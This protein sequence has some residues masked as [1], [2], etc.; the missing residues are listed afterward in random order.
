MSLKLLKYWFERV[1]ESCGWSG[2]LQKRCWIFL[3]NAFFLVFFRL[4]QAPASNFDG[5]FENEDVFFRLSKK[6][7]EWE[8][9]VREFFELKKNNFWS[10]LGISQ[11]FFFRLSPFLRQ[12]PK[13][14][15]P[16]APV[17]NEKSIVRP[18]KLK[19]IKNP[20]THS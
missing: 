17:T 16:T 9:G 5:V 12:I 15:P 2:M 18:L 14:R 6:D 7:S 20:F 11:L 8:L 19:N 13:I 10:T 3:K 1:G 4:S